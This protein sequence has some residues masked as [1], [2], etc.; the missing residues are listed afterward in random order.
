MRRRRFHADAADIFARFSAASPP[1]FHDFFFAISAAFQ[2]LPFL[3]FFDADYAFHFLQLR[4]PVIFAITFDFHYRYMIFSLIFSFAPARLM[5][6]FAFSFLRFHFRGFSARLL[7]RR[8]I[9]AA[10]SP[11][12]FL[13]CIFAASYIY[14]ASRWLH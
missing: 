12:S 10:D 6:D 5:P 11:Y 14:A 9:S 4:F 1:P 7:A 8:A 3:I 2:I 13:R